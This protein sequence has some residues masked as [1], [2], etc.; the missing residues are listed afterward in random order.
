MLTLVPSGGLGNRLRAVA[1]AV[2]ACREAGCGLRI[3]WARDWALGARFGEL[4]L[5]V[6]MDGVEIVEATWAD[7]LL[8]DRPRRHNLWLPKIAQAAA[9]DARIDEQQITPL[10]LRGFD[11]TGWLRGRRTWMSCYQ[12]FGPQE[13]A[14]YQ[15]LFRPVPQIE[16]AVEANLRQLGPVPIGLHIRRTDNAASTR[17]SPEALFEQAVRRAEG[18]GYYLATDDSGVRERF[19]SLFPGKIVSPTADTSRGNAEGIRAALV[20]MF[21]L[22]STRRIYASA[23]STFSV[24]AA[25]LGQAEW[26]EL[27]VNS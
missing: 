27:K 24:V 13:P 25:R 20:D 2:A 3:V 16:Q 22:A 15:A 6:A 5:P 18:T 23:D 19:L 9:Y 26:E 17:L 4:F 12:E 10:K 11:F 1:S 14:L 7:L 21:T 8:R